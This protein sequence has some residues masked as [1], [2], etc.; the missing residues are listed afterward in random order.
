M[1]DIVTPDQHQAAAIVDRRRIEHGEPVL[2]AASNEH[3]TA[4]TP[5]ARGRENHDQQRDQG[6]KPPCRRRGGRVGEQ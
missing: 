6:Q 4:R 2:A 1:L 3:A 5:H